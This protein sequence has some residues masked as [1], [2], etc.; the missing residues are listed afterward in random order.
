MAQGRILVIYMC[1]SIIPVR[2]QVQVRAVLLMTTE[3]SSKMPRIKYEC[4][5]TEMNKQQHVESWLSE[6]Q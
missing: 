2:G 4:A 1:Y 5:A 6:N 3:M